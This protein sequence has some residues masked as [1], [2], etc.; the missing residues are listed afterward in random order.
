MIYTVTTVRP[1]L[2]RRL[3]RRRRR[4]GR[5]ELVE[6]ADGEQIVVSCVETGT[7]ERLLVGAAAF[8]S[9]NFELELE[10]L[11]SDGLQRLAAL[12]NKPRQLR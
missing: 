2:N 3:A 10:I 4:R 5:W 11:R 9:G 8:E 6:E 1:A 7:D 12:N